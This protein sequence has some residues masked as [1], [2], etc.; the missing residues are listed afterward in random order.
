LGLAICKKL[1][2]LMDGQIGVMSEEGNGSTFWFT[3]S[4]QKQPMDV[5]K[6][7]VVN[8]SGTEACALNQGC[9]SLTNQIS[10]C[11]FW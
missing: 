8:G 4:L 1:I 2:A 9:E 3:V 7:H 10:G 5:S 11:K 6:A